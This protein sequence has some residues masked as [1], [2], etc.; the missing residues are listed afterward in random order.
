M[1]ETA[2]AASE[3]GVNPLSSVWEMQQS[4]KLE[5]RHF[6]SIC[7]GRCASR[8]DQRED[9]VIVKVVLNLLAD[10]KHSALELSRKQ[11]L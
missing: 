10:D 3:L 8:T 9:S 6:C 4:F 11:S 1:V 5:F 7:L 2:N